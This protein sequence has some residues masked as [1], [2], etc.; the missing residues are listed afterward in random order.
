MKYFTREMHSSA[1]EMVRYRR[2]NRCSLQFILFT[3]IWSIFRFRYSLE[4]G[5]SSLFQKASL[6]I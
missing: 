6:P 2:Y 1:T 3:Y 5:L 4:K